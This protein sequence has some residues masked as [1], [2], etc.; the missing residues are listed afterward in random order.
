MSNS[1]DYLLSFPAVRENTLLKNVYLWMSAG[2]ALTGA[3]AYFTANSPSL[4]NIIYGGR[5]NFWILIIA[6]FAL[7]WYLSSRIFTMTPQ[8][9]TLSFA[10]YSV[11]NGLT[12]SVIFLAYTGATISGAFFVTAATFAATSFYGLTTKRNLSGLGHYM[13]MALIGIIIASLV[14]MFLKS[15]ALY[16][17]VS[18]AGVAVFI[19]LTAYDTQVIKGWNKNMGENIAEAD[20]MR[21]S[22]LGAL[23]LYLDFINLFLFILRIF[24]RGRD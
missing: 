18:Y 16:W 19:G 11:L 10:A 1:R 4:L 5:F 17:L 24:G 9:A 13:M 2:L 20:F 22:I 15:S 6:E 12:L 7:V 21:L 3:V 23:K 14:N 8:A